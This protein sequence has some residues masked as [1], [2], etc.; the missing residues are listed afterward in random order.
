MQKR[1]ENKNIGLLFKDSE[2]IDEY[3]A[4]KIFRQL[5][6]PQTENK[7]IANI[8]DLFGIKF[9]VVLKLL[10]PNITH[11]TEI[12]GVKLNIKSI[13]ELKRSFEE[14]S[15]KVER[16]FPETKSPKFILQKMEEGI[17]EVLLGFKRDPEIG[18]V[19][20]LGVGGI[21]AELYDDVA[22][23]AAPVDY[24]EACEMIKE[25]DGLAIIRGYRSAPKGDLIALAKAITSISKLAC[26]EG[27]PVLEAEINPLLVKEDGHGVIGLDSLIV[28]NGGN[29]KK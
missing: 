14:I 1:A 5:G 25:V 28:L 12:G 27:D 21:L 18:P 26:S 29:I 2:K 22:I 8:K 19:V 11:K 20:L 7:K 10:S 17:A 16:F 3:Y 6:I 23:R 13:E 4:S 9:P 24:R 15:E